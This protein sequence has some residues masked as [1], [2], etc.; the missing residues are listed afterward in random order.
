MEI[1]TKRQTVGTVLLCIGLFVGCYTPAPVEPCVNGTLCDDGQA[2]IESVC[3]GVPVDA[4]KECAATTCVNDELSECGQ[5]R[6]CALGCAAG[7][8]AR[9]N[10]LLPSNNVRDWNLAAGTLPFTATD[11]VTFYTDTGRIT[12]NVMGNISDLRAPGLGV[13]AGIY[14]TDMIMGEVAIKAVFAMRDLAVA[15]TAQLSFVGTR[16]VVLLIDGD[17][18]IA[19]V[20]D[21]SAQP[22][23]ATQVGVAGPG[24]A[25]GGATGGANGTGCGAGGAGRSL[26][27]ADSGGGG[28][29][30][31][32]M[33]ARGGTTTNNGSM[34][35]G[36]GPGLKCESVDLQPLLG[37][38]GGAVSGGGPNLFGFGGSGGGA[39]Q[40]SIRGTLSVSSTGSIVASGSG[41]GG[42]RVGVNAGDAGGGGGGGSG[43]S[44]LL[45]ASNV[46][47]AGGVF[48]N[49]GGGGGGAATVVGVLTPGS[50]GEEGT[51]ST[52]PAAGGDSASAVSGGD[53]GRGG[54][55]T[56]PEL[57]QT[58]DFNA[59]GGGGSAGKI[60]IRGGQVALLLATLSP[61]ATQL[62]ARTQ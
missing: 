34:V 39:L 10:D 36:G 40:V 8:L 20:I 26:G 12:V 58:A 1:V 56:G 17:A 31:R 57:G 25:T 60:I 42:G 29:G 59:G 24:G 27:S 2:C 11:I 3:G 51:R 15:Q 43:G 38:S 4:S 48:A 19:G 62:P 55:T 28:A 22:S 49:G 30:Y 7:S 50:R 33:G 46:L 14:F 53:G 47:I 13:K 32:D 52:R 21:A 23:A 37:G 41:G 35:T 5:S 44:L 9:C 61:A 54:T 6:V 16:P 18:A 45:E